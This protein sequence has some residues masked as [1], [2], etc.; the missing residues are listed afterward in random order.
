MLSKGDPHKIYEP[1]KHLDEGAN[2]VVFR[3]R[4]TKKPHGFVA[5]KV[6]KL[7]ADSKMESIEN[8][9]N[10]MSKVSQHQNIVKYFGCHQVTQQLWVVMEYMNTAKLTNFIS[11]NNYRDFKEEQIAAVCREVLFGL[12]FLHDNLFIH[13]D[14]K[15][16]NILIN[17][18]M[19]KDDGPTSVKMADFGFC[20]MLN[21]PTEKRKSTVGTPYWSM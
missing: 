7:K 16:D 15:S 2:A 11:K 12:K 21:S 10:I 6:I 19:N 20:C 4:Q 17:V 1:L 18:H 3:T 14:L 9:L 5:I 8:E 13:R